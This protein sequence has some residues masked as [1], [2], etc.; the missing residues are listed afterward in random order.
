MGGLLRSILLYRKSTDAG[1][2]F[3]SINLSANAESPLNPK[4][5]AASNGV[6]ANMTR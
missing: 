6:Y 5:A 3:G 4:V 1:A 2:T